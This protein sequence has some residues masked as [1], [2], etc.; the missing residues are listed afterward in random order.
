MRN[1]RTFGWRAVI[2]AM[3][4]LAMVCTAFAAGE[5]PTDLSGTKMIECPDCGAWGVVLDAGEAVTCG[6]CGGEG[7][8]RS[9][10]NF[11]NTPMALLPPV[12][13]IALARCSTPLTTA[14]WPPCPTATTWAS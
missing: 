6:T 9:P 8:I 3:M 4:L 7:Y 10:S 12:I 5:D 13:A 14:L 1:R 2:L 11:F